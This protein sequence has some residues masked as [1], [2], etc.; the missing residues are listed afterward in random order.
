LESGSLQQYQ[1][2]KNMLQKLIRRNAM[3]KNKSCTAG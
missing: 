3:I 2:I 1:K